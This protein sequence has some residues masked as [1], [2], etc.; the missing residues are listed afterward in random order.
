[1]RVAGLMKS[2][3]LIAVFAVRGTRAADTQVGPSFQAG[4]R[5][6]RLAGAPPPGNAPWAEYN[7]FLAEMF[8][9]RFP[10]REPTPLF[11]DS[12][13]GRLLRQRPS[14]T[15]TRRPETFSSGELGLRVQALLNNPQ[16]FPKLQ[17]LLVQEA[18]AVERHMYKQA[19]KNAMDAHL[20]NASPIQEVADQ[21]RDL[22]DPTPPPPPTPEGGRGARLAHLLLQLLEAT[23]GRPGP[24]PKN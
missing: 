1:M 6:R 19:Q 4:S 12:I 3:L 16:H 23:E 14:P 5:L 11:D 17:E 18:E 9:D 8:E 20:Q 21:L 13:L 7:Q 10:E 24:F 2:L 22:P 15:P